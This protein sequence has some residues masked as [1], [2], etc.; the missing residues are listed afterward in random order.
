MESTKRLLLRS[1]AFLLF[2]G[3]ATGGFVAAAMTGKV[4][5]DASMALAS[6]L[7]AIL[8]AFMIFGLAISLQY[9]RYTDVGQ[10]RLAWLII[11]ANYANWSVTALKAFLRVHGID[12]VGEARNDLIFLLL[13]LLVVIPSLVGTWFWFTGFRKDGGKS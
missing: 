8:G 9:L 13:T 4:N 7:N 2:L 11:V 1:G 6:H 12:F 5:A 3:M 10:R